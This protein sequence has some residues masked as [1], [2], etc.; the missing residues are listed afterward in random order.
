[1]TVLGNKD[2]PVLAGTKAIVSGRKE[3]DR[4]EQQG[5]G[6]RKEKCLVL[7]LYEALY[8]V[9][10]GKLKVDS[11]QGK[12]LSEKSLLA[13][14]LQSDK[15]FYENFA[16]FS[17][18]RQKGYVVKTGFKFGCTFRVYP[19]GKNPGQEHTLWTVNVCSQNAKKSMSELSRISRLAQ[20]LHTKALLAVVDSEDKVN[21]YTIYRIVP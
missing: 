20:N 12:R 7:D 2:V 18:L 21:Y 13:T 16:V 10:R 6:E 11:L 8:L 17:D 19:K 14:G 4:L 3:K 9:E 1:M 15:G 5:F